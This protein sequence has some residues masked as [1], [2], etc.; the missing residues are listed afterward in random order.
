MPYADIADVRAAAAK[1]YTADKGYFATKF[2]HWKAKNPKRYAWLGQRHTSRQRGVEFN[3]TFEQWRDWWGE[4]FHL[5]GKRVSDLQMCRYGDKG[6]YELGNI[7][8]ATKHENQVSPRL[9]EVQ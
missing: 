5:R 3:L 6:A 9:K 2:Q 1:A 7:Y 4:D 8:K